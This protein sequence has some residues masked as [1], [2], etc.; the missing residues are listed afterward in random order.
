MQNE[1]NTI[2]DLNN[3]SHE[4]FRKL[5]DIHKFRIL[6]IITKLVASQSVAE[7]LFQKVF[8]KL[9]DNRANIDPEGSLTWYL[10]VMA[11]NEVYSYWR[12]TMNKTYLEISISQG[13]LA[14]V[15]L[16]QNVENEDYRKYLFSLAEGLPPKCR[17][18]FDMHFSGQMS[19]KEI[20]RNLDISESTVENQV[21]KA[22]KFIRNRLGHSID[23]VILMATSEFFS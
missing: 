1:A 5:Y 3:G 19:Y 17:Q 9:W 2:R 8:V 10:N 11:R 16:D 21:S 22:L 20:A 12:R 13:V 4:A 6:G 14:D 23:V 18:I 15:V 7:E